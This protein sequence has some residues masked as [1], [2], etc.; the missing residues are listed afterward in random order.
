MQ[1]RQNNIKVE[2]KRL[3]P[4][5]KEKSRAAVVRSFETQSRHHKNKRITYQ[6]TVS[7]STLK[8][9]VIKLC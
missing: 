4:K 7:P 2:K 5:K 1:L 8:C 3:N 9:E 6:T